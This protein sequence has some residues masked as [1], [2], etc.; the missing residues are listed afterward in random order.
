MRIALIGAGGA[1]GL[2]GAK[3]SQAGH[4]VEFLA[5][6]RQ[7]EALRTIGL[8]VES[9]SGGFALQAPV[10]AYFDPEHIV[11]PEVVILAIKAGQVPE[12]LPAVRRMLGPGTIVVTIQNGVRTIDEVEKSLGA[13]VTYGGTGYFVS[14][15]K[16]PGHICHLGVDPKIVFGNIAL[17]DRNDKTARQFLDALRGANIEA[18]MVPNIREVLWS[19]VVLAAALGAIGSL[20]RATIGEFRRVPETRHVL[21]E[22]MQEVVRV[23]AS[24]GIKLDASCAGRTLDFVDA[25]PLDSTSSLQRDIAAGKPSELEYVLGDLVRYSIAARVEAPFLGWSYSCLRATELKAH[26]SL[27]AVSGEL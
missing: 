17:R 23:A 12:L 2:L 11:T 8:R 5:R 6:G 18:A 16:A 9:P 3:L 27:V 13:N 10:P 4:N 1:G 19:K 24:Q 25:M 15:L 20:T 26:S 21:S 22:M 7:W 14:Y